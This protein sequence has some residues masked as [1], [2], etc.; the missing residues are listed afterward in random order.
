VEPWS[1]FYRLFRRERIVIPA[2]QR[3]LLQQC[4]P[5]VAPVQPLMLAV[6][7]VAFPRSTQRFPG[8]GW[9]KAPATAPWRPGLALAQRFGALHWLPPLE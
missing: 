3:R 7:A 9:R 6:D 4:L 2:V 8:V 5:H 1:P